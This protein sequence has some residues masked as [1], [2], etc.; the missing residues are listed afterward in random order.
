M[1]PI[2]HA[3]LYILNNTVSWCSVQPN[4][5]TRAINLSDPSSTILFTGGL[6]EG[7]GRAYRT[8]HQ[9]E[10]VNSAFSKSIAVLVVLYIV[11]P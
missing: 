2:F 7:K 8:L 10:T 4:S 3:S 5:N 11:K 9:N 6:K 1:D